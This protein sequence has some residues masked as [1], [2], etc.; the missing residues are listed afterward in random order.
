MQKFP[1]WNSSHSRDKTGSLTARP[2]G[3]LWICF[4][5][6][7]SIF[8]KQLSCK[9]RKRDQVC[10]ADCGR[11]L[12]ISRKRDKQNPENLPRVKKNHRQPCVKHFGGGTS[13]EGH[14]AW[15]CS[16]EQGLANSGPPPALVNF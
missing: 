6:R 7:N 15:E 8:L 14:G 9:K 2:P 4:F 10:Y 12:P 5:H 16:R 13:W 3:N 11:H 1:G